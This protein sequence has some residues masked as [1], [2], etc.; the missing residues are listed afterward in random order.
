MQV[1]DLKISYQ[2]Q[3]IQNQKLTSPSIKIYFA[4]DFP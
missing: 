4:F 2:E 3:E 1:S